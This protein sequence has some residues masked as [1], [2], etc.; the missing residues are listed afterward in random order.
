M[1]QMQEIIRERAMQYAGEAFAEHGEEVSAA[2]DYIMTCRFAARQ[3]GLLA[4]DELA[5][6]WKEEEEIPLKS[7]LIG[8]LLEIVDATDMEV[9][10]EKAC[11]RILE[12]GYSGYEWYIANLYVTGCKNLYMGVHHTQYYLL[13]RAMVPERWLEDFDDYWESW[14]NEDRERYEAHIEDWVRYVFP[15]EAAIRAAF[16]RR[17][18]EIEPEGL[19]RILEELPDKILAAALSGTGEPL[20]NRFLEQMSAEQRKAVMEEWY[21]NRSDEYSLRDIEK[22]MERMTM[23]AGL[24]GAAGE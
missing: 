11:R 23:A 12:S 5:E 9:W 10:E 3:S 17:F 7:L 20:R 18:G 1:E 2:F 19:Q 24:M 15:R 21:Q 6:D 13:C 4:L 22:A 8:M 16:H 14:T